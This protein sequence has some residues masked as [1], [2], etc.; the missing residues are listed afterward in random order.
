MAQV[1]QGDRS[2]FAT[3]VARHLDPVHRYL[4]RLSGSSAD[5]DDLSQETFLRV[6]QRAGSYRPGTV[7][8]TTWLHRVAHNLA[9]DAARRRREQTGVSLDL[10]EDEHADPAT[11][12]ADDESARRLDGAIAALPPNQR[13]ALLLCQVQGFSNRDAGAILGVSVRSLESL[14]ARA[15]R[16][17]RQTLLDAEPPQSNPSTGSTDHDT[18]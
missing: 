18:A 8:F 17:L 4:S 10:V 6:W 5:A 13:A 9:V 7:A 2:A 16:N 12:A 15:R 3:L 14:L 1:V 11:R